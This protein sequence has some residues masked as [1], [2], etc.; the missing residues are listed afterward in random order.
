[1]RYSLKRITCCS[2]G[3]TAEFDDLPRSEGWMWSK[4][5]RFLKMLM[6]IEMD[7]FQSFQ[8]VFFQPHS[9]PRGMTH[10][11]KLHVKFVRMTGLL[12]KEGTEA[13]PSL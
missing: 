2:I 6:R 10:S 4:T 5:D 9:H 13:F 8:N 1:M 11:R 7:W 3:S 12:N